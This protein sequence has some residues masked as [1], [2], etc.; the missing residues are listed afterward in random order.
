MATILHIDTALETASVCLTRNGN[1]EGFLKNEKQKDHAA[2]LHP[3]LQEIMASAGLAMNQLDG[4]AV[5]IGPGS[6][7]GLRVGLAT[8]K[9]LC[10]GLR[11]PLIPVNTLEMMAYPEKDK[12]ASLFCPMINARRMEVFMAVYD[13]AMNPVVEPKAMI[14]EKDSFDSLLKKNK[15]IF[16]GSGSEKLKAIVSHPNALFSDKIATTADMAPLSEKYFREKKFA[17]V[18]YVEPL[19]IKEFYSVAR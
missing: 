10:F 11:I 18:V 1:T 5:T 6:Y 2:W 8:A 4:I 12:N 15:V 13:K 19:Y 16:S 9:G 7:T 3:A 17:D 14:I